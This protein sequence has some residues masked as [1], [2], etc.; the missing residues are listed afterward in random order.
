MRRRFWSI[1]AH[2]VQK[3]CKLRRTG[4]A[5]KIQQTN[6]GGYGNGEVQTNEATLENV[7]DLDLF[8]TVQLLEETPAVQ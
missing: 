3:G 5:S 2:A 7:H 6:D 1:N 4:N 8:V